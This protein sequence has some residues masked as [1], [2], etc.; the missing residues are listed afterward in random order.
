MILARPM[1]RASG[2]VLIQAVASARHRQWR[3]TSAWLVVMA[4]G[5]MKSGLAARQ[6][7]SV[8][9]TALGCDGKPGR[10]RATCRKRD[11]KW[12]QTAAISWISSTR[13]PFLRQWH[14]IYNRSGVAGSYAGPPNS[15]SELHA[16]PGYRRPRAT[17]GRGPGCDGRLRHHLRKSS[18]FH[19][20]KAGGSTFNQVLH[21]HFHGEA[22]NTASSM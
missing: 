9:I 3:T 19:V 13:W 10:E 6:V 22:Q 17:F 12:V 21:S 14:W 11:T 20:A 18:Y 1:V 5:R 4:P 8:G 2:Q 16:K 7:A 15:K